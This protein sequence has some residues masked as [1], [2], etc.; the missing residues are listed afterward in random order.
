MSSPQD[1]SQETD[2]RQD[3][4]DELHRR[5][6]NIHYGLAE[7]GPTDPK[8]AVSWALAELSEATAYIRAARKAKSASPAS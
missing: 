3:V 1:Q 2:T 4:L 7:H 5:L 8:V 6:V